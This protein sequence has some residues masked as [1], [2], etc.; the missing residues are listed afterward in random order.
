MIQRPEEESLAYA[1]DKPEY[2]L[3]NGIT[4]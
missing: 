2:S 1:N 4:Q 3:H